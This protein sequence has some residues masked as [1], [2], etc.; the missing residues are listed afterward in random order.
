[1]ANIS[2]TSG[3]VLAAVICAGCATTVL[4]G[5]EK[6]ALSEK[7]RAGY[8]LFDHN[9]ASCHGED[10]RGDEGPDLHGLTKSDERIGKIV[11]NGIKGEMPAFG[12]KFNDADIAAIIA[13]LRTLK[14]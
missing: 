8:R 1:M 13:Y 6:S 12:K 11:R 14:N 9:C 3:L 2:K 7:A 10:A 5:T 4:M